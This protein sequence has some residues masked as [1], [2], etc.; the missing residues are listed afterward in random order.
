MTSTRV[1]IPES[2]FDFGYYWWIDPVRNI[3]FMWGH[4]GQFAFICPD[5]D[6]VVIITSEP[7]T[8]GLHQI[9]A[10]EAL[11]IVDRIVSASLD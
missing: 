11:E 5:T 4:G 2:D 6:I 8:Q 3:Q 10:D 1:E 9:D 7:N